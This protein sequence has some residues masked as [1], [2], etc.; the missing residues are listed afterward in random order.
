MTN[1]ISRQPGNTI[2]TIGYGARSE[3]EFHEVLIGA[4]IGM[5]ADVRRHP[6]SRRH[7]PPRARC[8]GGEPS[9]SRHHLR[10]VG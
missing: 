10:V 9:P 2:F 1:A 8:L 7:P 6:G 3:A 4:E 5:L